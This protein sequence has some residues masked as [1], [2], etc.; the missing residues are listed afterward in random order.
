M[1]DNFLA[2]SLHLFLVFFREHDVH[3][4]YLMNT[5]LRPSL[6]AF[7]LSNAEW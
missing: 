7:S 2:F 5:G 1:D 6:H 4:V 3:Y